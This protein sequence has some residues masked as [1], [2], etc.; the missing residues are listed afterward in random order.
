MPIKNSDGQSTTRVVLDKALLTFQPS[1]YNVPQVVTIEAVNDYVARGSA[2]FTITPNLLSGD[3]SYMGLN[4]GDLT[5]ALQDDE[6]D[7]LDI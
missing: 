3:F 5:I 2:S 1:D 6:V 7:C 4:T